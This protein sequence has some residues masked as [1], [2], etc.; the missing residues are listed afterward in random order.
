MSGLTRPDQASLNNPLTST[1]FDLTAVLDDVLSTVGLEHH[2]GGKVRFYGGADPLIDSPFLFA[3]AS[4]I[5]LAAKGVAASAIW[6]EHGGGDQDIAIDIRKAFQ[7]FSGFAD[8]RWEQI[9]GRRRRSSGTDQI[10]SSKCRSSALPETAG[11]WLRSMSTRAA[12]ESHRSRASC[13]AAA[14]RPARSG[15]RRL[16][17]Q[18]LEVRPSGRPP[19]PSSRGRTRRSWMSAA[20]CAC[21]RARARRSPCGPRV[22]SPYSAV[23]EIE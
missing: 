14:F 23:S 6:R 18:P 12:P 10:R 5:A 11:T 20:A 13:R 8:G 15:G 1:D 3:S 9:N 17:P 16:G 22:R 7:R 4:A 2:H 21:S 19:R